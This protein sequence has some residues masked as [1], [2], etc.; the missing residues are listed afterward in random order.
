MSLV[1]ISWVF[2]LALSATPAALLSGC[3]ERSRTGVVGGGGGS[4]ERDASLGGAGGAGAGG[5]ATG[6]MGGT[7]GGTGGF[8][9]GGV[10]GP[11]LPPGGNVIDVNRIDA[12]CPDQCS[13]PGGQ[14]CGRIGSA[15]G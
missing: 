15:C 2:V 4:A 8:G 12:L 6:G 9:T 11:P 7:T 13:F 1:T 3:S 14:L 5:T 10:I